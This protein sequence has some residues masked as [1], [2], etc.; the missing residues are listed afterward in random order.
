MSTLVQ[1]PAAEMVTELERRIADAERVHGLSSEQ[2]A[3]AVREGRVYDT[4]EIAEWL[5][6]YRALRLLTRKANS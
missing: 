3:R 5:V 4:A 6:A 1:R 2:M